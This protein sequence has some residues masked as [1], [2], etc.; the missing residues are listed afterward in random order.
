M[1]KP[2][3]IVQRQLDYYNAKD[4]D[5][6]CSTYTE[7]VLVKNLTDDSIILEGKPALRERYKGRFLNKNLFA[8]LTNRMVIGNKVIDYE[9]ITGLK[10]GSI[11]KAVA[12][13]E[14]KNEL[15]SKVWFIYE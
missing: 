4:L 15:I 6:F 13:Y 10:E 14:I 5:N 3:E 2:E 12:V 7:D 8:E 11:V 1:N 9:E